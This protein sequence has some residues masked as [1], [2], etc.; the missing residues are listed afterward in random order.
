[1]VSVKKIINILFYYFDNSMNCLTCIYA[2]SLFAKLSKF[3]NVFRYKEIRNAF[4]ACEV[5]ELILLL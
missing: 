5:C 3:G 2:G 4:E 1:V